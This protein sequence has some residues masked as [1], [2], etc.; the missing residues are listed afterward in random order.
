MAAL[1]S[2]LSAITMLARDRASLATHVATGMSRFRACRSVT[3]MQNGGS[4]VYPA[5]LDELQNELRNQLLIPTRE[6]LAAFP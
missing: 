5:H 3:L 2:A 4:T 1:P 6:W